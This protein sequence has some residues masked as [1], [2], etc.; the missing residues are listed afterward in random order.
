MVVPRTLPDPTRPPDDD[1][2]PPT[3]LNTETHWWDGSQ[4]YGSRREQQQ[5]LRSGVDG[6]LRDQR[7][8]HAARCRP[9]RS[10]T[11]RRCRASGSGWR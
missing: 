1:D 3:Y 5:F 4:L 7:R 8:R 11:R 6:K 2:F 10:T 9:T